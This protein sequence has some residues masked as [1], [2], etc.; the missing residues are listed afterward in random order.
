MEGLADD[1]VV[2]AMRADPEPM[3]AARN[4]LSEC[5]VVKANSNAM[6]APTTYCLELQRP[7]R[8]VGLEERIA[9]MCKAL[10]VRGKRFKALPEPLGCRVLQS[11][12]TEPAR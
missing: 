5:S 12:R 2:L 11:S 3:D 4:R 10:N 8:W 6:K 1:L 9:S 7:M